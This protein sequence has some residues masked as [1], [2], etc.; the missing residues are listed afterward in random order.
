V[1][2][3]SIG[4]RGRGPSLEIGR[5]VA[6]RALPNSSRSELGRPQGWKKAMKGPF[7]S[8]S[9]SGAAGSCGVV[10]G[11]A[12]WAHSLQGGPFQLVFH[13]SR[14]VSATCEQLFLA[15]LGGAV[16]MP[17]GAGRGSRSPYVSGS[18]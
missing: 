2:I 9:P 11:G 16:G 17:V 13:F 10:L 18:D 1:G 4:Q 15:S 7:P 6:R 3:S 8:N 5:G 12:E 14:P